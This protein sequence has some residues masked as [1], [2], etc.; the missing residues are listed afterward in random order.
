MVQ[1]L[2]CS[3]P[4]E[5]GALFCPKCLRT[6]YVFEQAGS[7]S[8]GALGGGRLP[9]VAPGGGASATGVRGAPNQPSVI[10]GPL[11]ARS[12]TGGLQ[13]SSV[14]PG[15]EGRARRCPACNAVISIQAAVCPVCATALPPL[16][17]P[18]V[19]G[20]DGASEPH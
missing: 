1:C 7:P 18:P 5:E 11:P 17:A 19:G 15:F 3:A 20:V 10:A 12:G 9:V 14:P 2:Y 13:S 16:A 6:Q 4:L 8:A